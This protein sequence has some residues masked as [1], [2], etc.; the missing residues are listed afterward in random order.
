M[1][2]FSGLNAVMSTVHIPEIKMHKAPPDLWN[3]K[4]AKCSDDRGHCGFI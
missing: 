3:S 2:F 1:F 4:K